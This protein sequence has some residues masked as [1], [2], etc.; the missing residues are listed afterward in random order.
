M[1]RA[2]RASGGGLDIPTKSPSTPK[3]DDSDKAGMA[4]NSS[5]GMA[6]GLLP[7]L[8]MGKKRGGRAAKA[9]GGYADGGKTKWIQKAIKHP[10]SLHK[11]L[12]VAEGEKIPE[13]KLAK[14]T[15]SKN[16]HVAKKA[17]LAETLK[18]FHKADG[19]SFDGPLITPKGS[20]APVTGR[21]M[22]SSDKL[23]PFVPTAK[24]IPPRVPFKPSEADL[25]EA[26]AP[27][28][29]ARKRGGKVSVSDGALEGTRPTGGRLARKTGGRASKGKMNVN[30]IIGAGPKGPAGPGGMGPADG[31]M[32]APVGLRQG[33]N[34]QMPPPGPAGAPPA[35]PMG[36]GAMPPGGMPPGAPPMMGRK[37][38]GRV[39]YPIKDGAGG[40][41]GRLQ[42]IKAYGDEAYDT[43][44]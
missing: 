8:M 28:V 15:H 36:P 17:R 35:P 11:A 31:G 32:G 40:G 5:A 38:G 37:S 42:K 27:A 14:A 4:L 22:V 44:S 3:K 19:G 33:L 18:R 24:R 43:E 7:A 26:R 25:N 20:G 9:G 12:H 29:K 1:G 2:K 21:P 41:L 34:P 6:A 23:V 16:P 13:K 30:I 39:S 10:G